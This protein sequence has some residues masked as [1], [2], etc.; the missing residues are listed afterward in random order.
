MRKMSGQK[1][2]RGGKG[3]IMVGLIMREIVIDPCGVSDFSRHLLNRDQDSRSKAIINSLSVLFVSM[4][5]LRSLRVN[6]AESTETQ[7]AQSGMR[8]STVCHSAACGF[9]A[10]FAEVAVPPVR[11]PAALCSLVASQQL[12]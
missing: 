6:C 12:E 10:L 3:M 8:D 11:A 1:I 2:W 4:F 9:A 5:S 7:R